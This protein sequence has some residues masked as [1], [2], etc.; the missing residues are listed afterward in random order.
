M[1]AMHI[2]VHP[3]PANCPG[4]LGKSWIY[5]CCPL[6]H[7]QD[8]TVHVFAETFP[9]LFCFS[10]TNAARKTQTQLRKTQAQLWKTQTQPRKIRKLSC[11][12]FRKTMCV[13]TQRSLEETFDSQK[14]PS[15]LQKPSDWQCKLC[16]KHISSVPNVGVIFLTRTILALNVTN[17]TDLLRYWYRSYLRGITANI[18]SN[19]SYYH[20][21]DI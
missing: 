10:V 8:A 3:I 14:K 16:R 20:N 13:Q 11:T 18:C 5:C 4:N 17:Y 21:H 19:L 1:R 2:S 7:T 6:S 9:L 15:D 12:V